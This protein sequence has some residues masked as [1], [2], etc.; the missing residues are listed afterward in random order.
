MSTNNKYD[1]VGPM[2]GMI[3]QVYYYLLCLLQL[4]TGES[5]SLERYDDV[6]V[7]EEQGLVYYQ[8]K[9]T[10]ED[11]K[12]MTPRDHDLWKTL[13][14]WVEIVKTNRNEDEQRQWIKQSQFV[15]L[16]NKVV[17]VN[18]LYKKLLSFHEDSGKWDEVEEHLKLQANKNKG[19][20][21]DVDKYATVIYSFPLRK[22]LLSKVV[23]KNETDEEI[24]DSVSHVLRYEQ[25]VRE[26]N[27]T[28]LREWLYGKL[29]ESF[30]NTIQKLKPSEYNEETFDQEYGPIIRS[31][32]DRIFVSNYQSFKMPD[33]IKV[34]EQTFMRQLADIR[35]PR[36]RTLRGRVMLTKE[37]LSFENDYHDA[38]KDMSDAERMA[39][40]KSVH[41]TWDAI[42]WSK[43]DGIED[44]TEE[45]KISAAKA[46]LTETRSQT[47]HFVNNEYLGDASNG[48][49][50]YFS[51]GDQP[52]IGWRCDWMDL[53]N[54]K[55]WIEIYG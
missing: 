52:T 41:S 13:A 18:P 38:L 14:M 28:R 26:K 47:F 29:V 16:T 43:N 50:Y 55:D 2:A 10:G 36:V 15:L 7:A 54:G 22:E 25:H 24:M 35:D 20:E 1:A 12:V 48:C 11:A 8:L 23:I 21:N 34:E 31:M 5:A 46:V 45:K 17:G 6:A 44:K 3:Y 53:Y 4:R 30:V 49:I 51:D 32:R 33:N 19:K 40:E 9:H 42:F 37:R 39:F 27:V